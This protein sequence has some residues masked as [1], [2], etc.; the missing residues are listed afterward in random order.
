MFEADIACEIMERSVLGASLSVAEY[1][2]EYFA[3]T[4]NYTIGSSWSEGDLRQTILECPQATKHMLSLKPRVAHRPAIQLKEEMISRYES[5]GY[6][7]LEA[8]INGM[9]EVGTCRFFDC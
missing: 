4:T 6:Y 9:M 7:F 1:P 5:D 8:H 2:M 3:I